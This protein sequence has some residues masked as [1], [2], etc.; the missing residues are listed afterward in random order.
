ML[1]WYFYLFKYLTVT[2]QGLN[3]SITCRQSDDVTIQVDVFNII[4]P[5]FFALAWQLDNIIDK[6]Y[7]NKLLEKAKMRIEI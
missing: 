7:N 4:W 2:I 6:Y 3:N 5:K 1:A